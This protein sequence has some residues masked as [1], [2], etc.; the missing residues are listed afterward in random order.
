MSA[1]LNGTKVLVTGASSGIGLATVETFARR[2]AT[3]AL[4]YLPAD[5]RGVSETVAQLTTEGLS[6]VAVPGDVAQPGEAQSMVEQ[7]I[8]T[9]GGLDYLVSNAGVSCTREPI[10]NHDLNRL[11]EE[12]WQAILTTNLIGP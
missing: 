3:V 11:T 12:F 6:I 9:L 5:P 4:N 7:V 1:D 10:P 8:Q 2:G